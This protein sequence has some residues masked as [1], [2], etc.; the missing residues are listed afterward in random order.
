[1]F[2]NTCHPYNTLHYTFFIRKLVNTS[3][4]DGNTPSLRGTH[5]PLHSHFLSGISSR[6]RLIGLITRFRHIIRLVWHRPMSCEQAIAVT[7]CARTELHYRLFE[8]TVSLRIR[9]A[10]TF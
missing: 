3:V 5:T 10:F 1:M 6:I 9:H 7:L 8:N 2:F 4:A